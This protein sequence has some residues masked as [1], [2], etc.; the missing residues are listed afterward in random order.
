MPSART[1]LT[2]QQAD[3]LQKVVGLMVRRESLHL[4]RRRSLTRGS[5]L[6]SGASVRRSRAKTVRSLA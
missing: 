4:E 6:R 2:R 3:V 1:T 5:E